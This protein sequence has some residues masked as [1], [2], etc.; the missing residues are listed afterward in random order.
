MESPGGR[1]V[2]VNVCVFAGTSVSVN[3]MGDS[4]MGPVKTVFCSSPVSNTG[5][6]FDSLTVIMTC[7]DV[8]EIPSVASMVT[9]T[10]S[11]PSASPGEASSRST[12]MTSHD[13]TG[14]GPGTIESVTGSPSASL[15]KIVRILRPFSVMV[16]G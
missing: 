3:V 7:A 10:T 5:A 8:V 1:F 15:A 11:G 12:P 2:A 9:V 13:G 16:H 6:S 4:E 14:S